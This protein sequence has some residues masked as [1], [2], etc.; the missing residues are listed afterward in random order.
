MA[1]T[2]VSAVGL[3]VARRT[4]LAG[5]A[6]LLSSPLLAQT[7]EKFDFRALRPF[8]NEIPD[9]AIINAF[10]KQGDIPQLRGASGPGAVVVAWNGAAWL[11]DSLYIPAAGGHHD[12][13]GNEAYRFSVTDLAWRRTREPTAIAGARSDGMYLMA[14]LPQ[15]KG[16]TAPTARHLYSGICAA[17]NVGL[18]YFGG[19]GAAPETQDGGTW[20]YDP[21]NASYAP[22][23]EIPQS[24]YM[25]YE[26]KRGWVWAVNN[27]GIRAYDPVAKK[28]VLDQRI[29]RGQGVLGHGCCDMDTDTQTLVLFYGGLVSWFDLSRLPIIAEGG[30]ALTQEGFAAARS[31]RSAFPLIKN[32]IPQTDAI[33]S[34]YGV[35]YHPPS[36][37]FMG[38]NGQPDVVQFD[39]ATMTQKII[40]P[41]V[42]SKVPP[43]PTGNGVYGRWRYMAD[44]DAFI[45][46]ASPGS[47]M[48]IY[49]APV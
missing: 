3:P 16:P 5:V 11:A 1:K 19:F 8:W 42:G 40:R 12:Y 9:S 34:A 20:V 15:D 22:V 46:F 33:N 47:N 2:R 39:F 10:P 29:V 4:F 23:P 32:P 7:R 35:A 37:T 18:V 28:I 21:R 48:W 6:G 14:P 45:G 49:K 36:K 41:P 43:P 26:P 17:P 25:A 31:W 13:F 27:A 24:H 38:W 30:A 44:V